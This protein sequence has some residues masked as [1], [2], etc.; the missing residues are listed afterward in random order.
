MLTLQSHLIGPNQRAGW[1]WRKPQDAEGLTSRCNGLSP[2][3]QV[4]DADLVRRADYHQDALTVKCSKDHSHF[5]FLAV[6]SSS[7]WG[8]CYWREDM[9]TNSETN[10]DTEVC[11]C[12]CCSCLSLTVFVIIPFLFNF[13]SQLHGW[14][15]ACIRNTHVWLDIPHVCG[16]AGAL[17]FFILRVRTCSKGLYWNGWVA[18]KLVS[19]NL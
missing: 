19:V 8:I 12:Y 5:V 4:R 3:F 10:S 13:S 7:W 11:A 1:S 18:V 16:H 9:S 17:A 2:Q 6:S 14:R 15:K